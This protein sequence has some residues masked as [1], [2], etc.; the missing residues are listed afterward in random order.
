MKE[1]EGKRA[2]SSWPSFSGNSPSAKPSLEGSPKMTLQTLLAIDEKEENRQ[3]LEVDLPRGRS[4]K[5]L[6]FE[7]RALEVFL[8]SACKCLELEVLLLLIMHI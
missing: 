4:T 1:V 7:F 5:V 8:E 2:Q 6:P 3:G